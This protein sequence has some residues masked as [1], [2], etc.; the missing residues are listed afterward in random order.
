MIF[1]GLKW[2]RALAAR[3][4]CVFFEVGIFFIFSDDY[5]SLIKVERFILQPR[6]LL[7]LQFI[8]Q[9]AS[10]TKLTSAQLGVSI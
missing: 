8:G 2:G 5:I 4:F 1:F 7:R 6:L 9:F 10:R 3:Q